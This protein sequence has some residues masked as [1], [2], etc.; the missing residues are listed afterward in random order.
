MDR[1]ALARRNQRLAAALHQPALRHRLRD[2][3]LKLMAYAPV[4]QRGRGSKRVLVIRPDH[5]GDALLATP[6]IQQLKSARPDLEIHALC[7]SWTAELLAAYPVIDRVIALPFPGF[8]RQQQAGN[9]YMLALRWART[10]R[11][12][13]YAAAIVMRQDHWW[14]A[15]LA[16]L[17][18]IPRRIGY[19]RA[20]VSPF[21]TDAVALRHE[22]AVMQN[23]RLVSRLTDS[24]PPAGIRLT[25][26]AQASDRAN[27]AGRLRDLGVNGDRRLVCIHP[28]SGSASKLW[29]VDKW[30]AVA[31]R[32]VA[33][34]TCQIVFTGASGES[35]LIDEIRAGMTQP[36][37]NFGATNIGQLAALCQRAALALG[38]DSGVMHLAAA[39]DTP[40]VALFGPADPIEFAPWGDGARHITLSGDMSCAPCRILDWR[41]DDAKYHPCVRDIEVE[42]VVAAADRLLRASRL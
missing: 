37:I 35:A 11:E 12:S 16:W 19:D 14:G 42:S 40:T 17:A 25:Y 18:G 2:S 21:L 27:I 24:Q 10:L 15:W 8:A 4:P 5:L 30:A 31:D 23:L 33:D 1:Q 32:L 29:T 28:G 13:A 36:A 7:G 20:N 41:G 26:P 3:S 9:P 34:F 22:H 39:V 38:P 6:A